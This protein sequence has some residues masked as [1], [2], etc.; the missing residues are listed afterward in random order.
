MGFQGK[1][2]TGTKADP[3]RSVRISN[4]VWEAARRRA[5]YD[6]VTMSH[7]LVTFMEGYS[8]GLLDL[9]RISVNFAD[10]RRH[11]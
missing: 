6:G 1:R 4:E 11:G 9:P 8:Q 2:P 7:V 3:V 10:A 5:T